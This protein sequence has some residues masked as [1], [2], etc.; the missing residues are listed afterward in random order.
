MTKVIKKTPVVLITAFIT[1]ISLC[2]TAFATGT[3]NYSISGTA[4]AATITYSSVNHEFSRVV[5]RNRNL[6]TFVTGSGNSYT[7]TFSPSSNAD[8]I[9]CFCDQDSTNVAATITIP[10]Q[11]PGMPS[12]LTTTVILQP[13]YYYAMKMRSNSS[14]ATTSGNLTVHGLSRLC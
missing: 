8:T 5:D 13:N 9:V 12:T 2:V 10:K 4:S 11:S 1:V 7:I 3:G 14:S 6:D